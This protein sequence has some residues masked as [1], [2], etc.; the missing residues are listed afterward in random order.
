[1]ILS[2]CLTVHDTRAAFSA[3]KIL[4]SIVPDLI[5]QPDLQLFL[6]QDVFTA[7]IR[8]IHDSYF[9]SIQADLVTLLSHIYYLSIG[10]MP[11][12]RN[13][14]LSIPQMQSNIH[15]IKVFE[16]QMVEAKSERTRRSLMWELLVNHN[17][18]GQE[19][20]GRSET[21]VKLGADVATKE[22]I[23]RF[24]DAVNITDSQK[25][26]DNLLSKDEESGM[27]NLFG[28]GS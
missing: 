22:V 3:S 28:G 7:T 8:C 15:A 27:Q 13:I 24:Q 10:V 9:V 16:V 23:K 19:G 21:R 2:F 18:L 26:Q 17:I 14:L 4:R 20:F 1:M 11:I 25:E 12:P 6:C 5:K